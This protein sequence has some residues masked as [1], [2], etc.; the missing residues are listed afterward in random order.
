MA[1]TDDPPRASVIG[2]TSGIARIVSLVTFVLC[3]LLRRPL[4]RPKPTD[5]AAEN[6]YDRDKDTKLKHK[7]SSVSV[8]ASRYAISG[9]TGSRALPRSR[10][11]SR[12]RIAGMFSCSI[13]QIVDFAPHA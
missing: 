3:D 12:R 13:L 7:T 1:V 9:L 8:I 11:G 4:S 10:P 6:A 5:H 2:V